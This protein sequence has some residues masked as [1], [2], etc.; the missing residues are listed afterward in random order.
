MIVSKTVKKV[1]PF[2]PLSV[3]RHIKHIP[4]VAQ[5]Q[6]HI[7]MTFLNGHEFTHTVDAGPAKGI[8]FVVRLPED[9]GI[10][11]GTYELDFA[12]LL[13]DTVRR[14]CVV[15]YDIGGWH[16]FFAGVM[17]ANGAR[18]VHVF[19]PLPANAARIQKL[20]DLNFSS[21]ITLHTIA[22]GEYDAEMNL[23]VMADTSMAKLEVGDCQLSETL[24]QTI[25]VQVRSLDLMV[26]AREIPPPSL[27]KIDVEGAELLVL[28][29]A[30]AT[31][32]SHHPT[33]FAEIHSDVLLKQC[34]KLLLDEGY[35][36][37]RVES[38]PVSNPEV[39]RIHAF[40][41]STA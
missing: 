40:V 12:R 16:G 31:L 38:D 20:I 32:R 14:S 36:I 19:E 24:Q 35:L 4:G 2:I 30:R 21:S 18:E 5:L 9:K 27:M 11:T 28:R 26:L 17:A 15:C 13:A 10:W 1:L 37:D 39:C 41:R 34:T 29:G 8:T 7:V 23:M 33:I 3:R 6:R 22:L 25:R